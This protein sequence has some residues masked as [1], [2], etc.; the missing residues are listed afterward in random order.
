[1]LEYVKSICE[2]FSLDVECEDAV[3]LLRRNLLKLIDEREFDETS[4][5]INPCMTYILP[6]VNCTKCK[7]FRDVDLCRD[8]FTKPRSVLLQLKALNAQA[9][10]QH[11]NN[12]SDSN[13]DGD[14]DDY[15][16]E[17]EESELGN[18]TN[19]THWNLQCSEC[20]ELYSKD[21]IET[22]LL[23]VVRRRETAYHV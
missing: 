16:D 18:D 7:K 8:S 20:G 14:G 4:Q 15:D 11:H 10:P 12:S 17:N 22:M 2:V 1:A 13:N 5:F 9:N 19:I 3:L 21:L 6:D 23:E